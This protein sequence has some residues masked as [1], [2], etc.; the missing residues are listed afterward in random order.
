MDNSTQDT[1]AMPALLDAF[2]QD[3]KEFAAQ[4]K[5]L[6]THPCFT[7]G[8]LSNL[9]DAQ[10]QQ[11]EMKANIMLAY[12]HMEDVTMRL[13]K[14]VQ[15]V[16]GGVSIYDKLGIG[17]IGSAP[18]PAAQTANVPAT[19]SSGGTAPNTQG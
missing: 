5:Q 12:R 16:Q 15:A 13:G 1:I 19:P 4:I 2:R 3:T 14:V 9:P 17:T 7:D 18:A 6:M 11:S 8:S 10:T